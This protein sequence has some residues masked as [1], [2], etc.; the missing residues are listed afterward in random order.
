MKMIA[1]AMDRFAHVRIGVRLTMAFAIVL[2]LTALLG[3]AAIVNLSRVSQTSG[4]LAD[5]WLPSVR[6]TGEAR[7]ALLEVRELEV[8]H[9]RAADASYM[10]EY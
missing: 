3:A 4:E 1:H 5:K 10:A 6:D 7:A 9:S 2:T 8:K